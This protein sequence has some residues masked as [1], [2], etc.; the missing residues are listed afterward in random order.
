MRIF[1][2]KSGNV[3]TGT[4]P[5][6]GHAEGDLRTVAGFVKLVCG[7]TDDLTDF[8]TIEAT[9]E[10]HDIAL[11]AEESRKNGGTLIYLKK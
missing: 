5:V 10:S 11:A 1:G 6:S 2:G 7:E 3:F 8:T 9:V 4:M